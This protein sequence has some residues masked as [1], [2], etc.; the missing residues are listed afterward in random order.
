[1]KF[2]VPKG[3]YVVA[4]FSIVFFCMGLYNIS[5]KSLSCD[6]I[7]Y[8]PAGY[9]YLTK[10]DYWMNKEHPPLAKL[11]AGVPLLFLRPTLST[12]SPL[13]GVQSKQ[14]DYG[15]Q[16]LFRDN[17]NTDQMVF[18]ARVPNLLFGV[19]LGIYVFLWA[20][21]L[22]GDRAGYVALILA[23]FSPNILAESTLAMTDIGAACLTF[24]SMYYLWK[25]LYKDEKQGLWLAGV[26]LGLSLATKFTALSLIPLFMLLTGMRAYSEYR[27]HPVTPFYR[28]EPWRAML[29]HLTRT[30]AI[31]FGVL[32]LTYGVIHFDRFIAGLWYV[33]VHNKRGHPAFLMG[34]HSM[35]GW[36]HYFPIA[37]LIKTPVALLLLIALTCLLYRKINPKFTEALKRDIFLLLPVAI[38]LGSAV[39]SRLNIGIRHILPIYPFLFVFVSQIVLINWHAVTKYVV[40]SGLAVWYIIASLAIAPHYVAYFNE[41]IGGPSRGHHYLLDSNIDVGQD[42]KSLA[43]YLHSHNIDK[44]KLSYFGND[45]CDYRGIKCEE[46]GCTPQSGILAVSV[47]NLVGLSAAQAKCFVW[48]RS[49]RPIK[50]IGHSIFVYDIPESALVETLRTFEPDPTA[51]SNRN[52]QFQN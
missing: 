38:I 26:F 11:M 35:G 21:D 37:F 18:W 48:L 32:V 44:I 3:R 51:R 40:L 34:E 12:D 20:R 4:G 24:I 39:T 28:A 22:Y 46:L 43:A 47:N 2:F 10:F 31:A 7:I 29:L 25:F 41:L 8:L 1:M 5:A 50:E 33:I 16:F 36:P 52:C 9:S 45:S 14:L 30:F 23:S 27:R 42:L 15:Q 13:W 17:A 6:E 49:F 19:L